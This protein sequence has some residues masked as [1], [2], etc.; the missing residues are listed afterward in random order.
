MQTAVSIVHGVYP[1]SDNGILMQPMEY[2]LLFLLGNVKTVLPG[3]KAPAEPSRKNTI[4]TDIDGSGLLSGTRSMA[5][6]D[7]ESL[8]TFT[9]SKHTFNHERP[10]QL[11][12]HVAGL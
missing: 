11:R 6:R 4:V 8:K 10:G 12:T 9:T 1:G 2:V 3:I 7:E 5:N